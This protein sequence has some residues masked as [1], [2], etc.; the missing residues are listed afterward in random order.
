MI[1]AS[2][3]TYCNKATDLERV[4]RSALDSPIDII[5]LI[6]H[7]PGDEVKR[8]VTSPADASEEATGALM[9]NPK[10]RYEQHPNRGFGAGHN[11]AIR[12][13]MEQGAR[14]H[15]ILNPD[16]YW[17]D[18]VIET[19]AEYMDKHPGVGMMTPK[20]LFPDG[21]L[22]YNCKKLPTPLDLIGRRFLPKK[23]MKK[24]NDRF[25]LH[26]TGYD[27]IMNVPYIHGCFMLFRNDTLRK[28]GLFD[29]RF[30]MYP[31]DIDITRRLHE[32]SETLFYPH[33]SLYHAHGAASRKFGK[34]LWI[35]MTNMIR[36]F[37]KWGW[38]R[39]EGRKR[40]NSRLENKESANEIH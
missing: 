17:T 27:H 8:F 21:R 20:V 31:E 32:I 23:W 28:T 19:L 15:A 24:R 33:V 37:N 30:F 39:D 12:K 13:S 25:E 35:H 38:W 29:E 9:N 7:S 3:V 16:I 34:M 14:Y 18:P 4:L 22:Q 26:S 36:Y 2:I 1:T 10:V 5:Y 11:V 40:F 6:D